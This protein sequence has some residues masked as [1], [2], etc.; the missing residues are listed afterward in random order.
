MA[1]TV[2]RV[3]GEIIR[4]LLAIDLANFKAHGMAYVALK[5]A[6]LLNQVTLKRLLVYR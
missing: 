5:R 4:V 2:H 1:S 3:Q 6:R